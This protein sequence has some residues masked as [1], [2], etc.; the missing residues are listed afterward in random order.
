MA[1]T[2]VLRREDI[3]AP[4]DEWPDRDRRYLEAIVVMLADVT[5]TLEE[6][7]RALPISASRTARSRR[8]DRAL[9][10]L[11]PIRRQLEALTLDDL[12][13]V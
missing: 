7:G 10:I 13:E 6:R 3:E 4:P 11:Y 1:R 2:H 8:L 12:S 5:H 9:E